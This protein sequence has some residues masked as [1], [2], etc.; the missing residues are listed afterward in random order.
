MP[1]RNLALQFNANYSPGDAS[2]VTPLA[3]PPKWLTDLVPQPLPMPSEPATYDVEEQFWSEPSVEQTAQVPSLPPEPETVPS[4]VRRWASQVLFTSVVCLV[5]MLLA[6]EA[7]SFA[8]RVVV[9]RST[10]VAER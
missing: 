1:N 6:L 4:A 10:A 5:V 8:K 7:L 9:A 2:G 3:P